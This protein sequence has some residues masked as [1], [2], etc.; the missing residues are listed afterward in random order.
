MGEQCC[1]QARPRNAA[2]VPGP[3]TLLQTMLPR[4]CDAPR[5]GPSNGRTMLLPCFGP[6]PRF[7]AFAV[8][9]RSFRHSSTPFP[10]YKPC[11]HSLQVL[12]LTPQDAHSLRLMPQNAH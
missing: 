8:T 10:C 5:G 4:S 7:Q 3:A 9:S 11:S 1:G 2:T 12:L 6:V